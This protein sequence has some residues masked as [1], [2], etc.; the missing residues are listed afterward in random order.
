[1]QRRENSMELE[2]S[3][4][5]WLVCP[6]RWIQECEFAEYRSSPIWMFVGKIKFCA[7][8]PVVSSLMRSL[9]TN[10]S[11]HIPRKA[12][13]GSE[14]HR[15]PSGYRGWKSPKI[16]IFTLSWSCCSAFLHLHSASGDAHPIEWA[17]INGTK[18]SKQGR[19]QQ[20]AE[21]KIPEMQS[22]GYENPQQCSGP[23]PGISKAGL[24]GIIFPGNTVKSG[25]SSYIYMF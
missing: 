7:G 13:D 21:P 15:A 11:K 25:I 24:G 10:L 18:L 19:E 4:C 8:I 6:G 23:E 20:K 3:E 2:L 14:L 5:P 16:I 9:A 1:M 22:C 17:G 12:L